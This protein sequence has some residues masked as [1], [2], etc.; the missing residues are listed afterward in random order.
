MLR[1]DL[2]SFLLD[3]Y[4][5]DKITL[6]EVKSIIRKLELYPSSS[7]YDSNRQIMKIISD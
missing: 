7:L 6:N 4:I 1:E 2:Q 3:K 5:D